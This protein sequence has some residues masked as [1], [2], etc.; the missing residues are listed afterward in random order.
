MIKQDVDVLMISAG[1]SNLALAVA[2]EESGV[3]ELAT[4]TLVLEQCPDVKWQR[5]LL[6][7]WVRSQVSFLKDLVT[8][9]NPQ[10]RF[11]FLNYLH[12]QAELDAN[13]V[14]S[15][16]NFRA[17]PSA[18][19]DALPLDR[20][21]YV[22]VAG[23][24]LRD[25]VWHDTHTAPVPEPILAL[26]TELAHRTSLPAVMLERDGNYP[27]AATLSAELATIRTAA[28][29][30]PP[31]TGPPAA[32]PRNLVRLP[33]RPEPS[34]APAVRSELAAMQARLAEALVG[35]TEPP[36]DFDA[37]RVG[38]ARSAL[39]RKRSRAVARHAPAL[40]AKLGDRL[41]P[42]FADCAESWP[43]PP[44]GA[45]A[46]VAAFVSYLGTSLKTW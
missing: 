14:S 28:G 18:A 20:I 33:S 16:I 37:H 32:L 43:K 19:L 44:G 17:D 25:G 41:G 35:L 34:V 45:S 27:T 21:A 2:I 11:S 29:R 4:N 42:L 23:G 46:N 8:L 5:S 7:Q 6:L 10:S 24:E 36:P 1:P 3:P 15:A 38:V 39:G 13:L 26:L 30:E 40:A 31:N 22:H 9:R 12:E